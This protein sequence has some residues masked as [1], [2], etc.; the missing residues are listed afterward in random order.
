MWK[1]KFEKSHLSLP[2]K[3][4]SSESGRPGIRTKPN[5][6]RRG[7]TSQ[8]AQGGTR[9]PTAASTHLPALSLQGQSRLNSGASVLLPRLC[10]HPQAR[11]SGLGSE[12]SQYAGPGAAG[13]EVP[14]PRLAGSS[15]TPLTWRPRDAGWAGPRRWFSFPPCGNRSTWA[16][17][18]VF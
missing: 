3:S 5:G 18:G 13:I 10:H 9:G 4:F 14:Q 11:R 7:T 6:H 16:R 2:N 1:P 12:E 8:L 15:R 17:S